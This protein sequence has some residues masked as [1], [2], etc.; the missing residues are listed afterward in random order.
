MPPDLSAFAA[1]LFDP[2]ATP[3]TGIGP[4]HRFAIHRNNML[5][6]LSRVLEARFPV[7]R[8]LVGESFFVALSQ[9]FV[10]AMPPRS[11]VLMEYGAGLPAF[12]GSFP[13]ARDLPYLADMARLEWSLH[14]ASHGPDA[15]PL[16]TARLQSV[17]AEKMPGLRLDLHPTLV[18][19]N[20][21]YPIATIW[22]ANQPATS[23]RIVAA[24]LPGEAV[25]IVRPHLATHMEI[26]PAPA[27]PFI[28]GLQAGLTLAA[29]AALAGDPIFDLTAAL[30]LLLRR[31][32]ITDLHFTS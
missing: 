32:A 6:G 5:A 22:Q 12:I 30:V 25:L 13:A 24:D 7:V 19:L 26:V 4:A 11:P 21:G 10:A 20:S 16:D 2:G 1:A 31:N 17:P 28:T 23:S 8:R 14:V 29:A 18:L 3:P 15:E 27:L 9:A